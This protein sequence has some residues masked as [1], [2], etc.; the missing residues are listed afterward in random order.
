M[1]E[2]CAEYLKFLYRRTM[3]LIRSS[4]RPPKSSTP[5]DRG[6]VRQDF[7]WESAADVDRGCR[8]GA[9]KA[10]AKLVPGTS[11]KQAASEVMQAIKAGYEKRPG[12]TSARRSPREMG[13]PAALGNGFHVFLG[14]PV[15]LDTAP[16]RC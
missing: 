1:G 15:H 4:P 7:P 3:G 8:G 9:R 2:P 6:G 14:L 13:A 12:R 16:S 11:R 5:A 10:F